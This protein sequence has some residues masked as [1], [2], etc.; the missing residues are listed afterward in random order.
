MTNNKYDNI[1]FQDIGITLTIIIA[2]IYVSVIYICLGLFV[3]Y[4]LD[5]YVFYSTNKDFT[6]EY[7]DSTH[8]YILIFNILLTFSLIT[9]IA[10]LIRNLVQLL[11]FP[12]NFANI[13]YHSI[14]EV[15]TGAVLL[16]IMITFSQTLSKQ[17]KEI[18]FKLNGKIY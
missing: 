13:D 18:K 6:Q 2:I 14:R 5:K 10:Y 9:I 3:T 7:V 16:I 12:F 4:N 8:L 1:F 15:Y 11:P 17:Y